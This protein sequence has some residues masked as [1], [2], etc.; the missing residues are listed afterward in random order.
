MLGCR[1]YSG[2]LSC[3][4]FNLLVEALCGDAVKGRRGEGLTVKFP[5]RHHPPKSLAEKYFTFNFFPVILINRVKK[6]PL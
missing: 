6:V 3:D 5:N 4:A 1:L 2:T